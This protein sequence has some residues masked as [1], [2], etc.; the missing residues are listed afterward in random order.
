MKKQRFF[1]SKKVHLKSLRSMIVAYTCLS[2]ALVMLILTALGLSI[3]QRQTIEHGKN[4]L[5]GEATLLTADILKYNY[6]SDGN[7]EA[8][9]AQTDMM[10]YEHTARIMLIGQDYK[11]EYDTYS[12]DVGKTV[13]SADVI[14]AFDRKNSAICK[15]EYIR[16]ITPVI[17]E[18]NEEVLGVI[19]I[20]STEDDHKNI[21]IY[22]RRVIIACSVGIIAMVFISGLFISKWTVTP[23]KKMTKSIEKITLS[24]GADSHVEKRSLVEYDEIARTTNNMIDRIRLLDSTRQEFVANVSHELKTPMTSMK[25]LS[26]SLLSAGDEVDAAT[27]RE[28]LEDIVGEIDRE[29]KIIEDLLLIVKMDGNAEKLQIRTT[30]INELIEKI[31]KRLKPLATIKCVEIIFE[32]FRPVTAEVDASKIAIIIQN[33]CENAIKYNRENGNVRVTLNADHKYFY[34]NIEDTGIGIPQ[35]S[36][37]AVFERFYR[38]DKARSRQSGGT[39]LGLT[40]TKQIVLSH[41][42]TIKLYSKEDEGTTFSIRIPLNYSAKGAEE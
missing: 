25:V 42:G 16:I 41:N 9:E 7:K 2:C 38:V 28:F 10:A 30:D 6:F 15:G 23:L 8:I 11:V 34:I 32:S 20:M 21:G 29:N 35:E 17:D 27:Y 26:E 31:L 3:Y 33:L 18:E 4:K 19:D 12:C 37:E 40:I 39:G 14:D 36:L 24:G 1:S 13:I 22:A 5:Q